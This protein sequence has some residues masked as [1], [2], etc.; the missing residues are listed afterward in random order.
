MFRNYQFTYRKNGKH[1]FVPSESCLRRGHEIIQACSSAIDFPSSFFHYQ[2]GGHVAALH[3]H[4]DN[5]YFFRID[6]KDFFYSISR[7]RVAAALHNVGFQK[8]RTY[9][10][11]SS[12]KNPVPGPAYSLPIGFV[13]S[14]VLATLVMLQS[15][16]AEMLQ[17]AMSKGVF[18][19]LYFDD[20]IGSSLDRTALESVF[21]A[22]L[23]ACAK[24]NFVSNVE[25]LVE[26]AERLIAFNCNL[27]HGV[28]EVTEARVARFF[29]VARSPVAELAF[30]QYRERIASKNH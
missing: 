21:D 5:R 9:A 15:P 26:P 12:V 25:K 29:E 27:T 4:L 23:E 24:A 6:L 7:N 3:R 14:P 28:A 2:P 30:E 11:W 10:K 19:S 18:I 22:T 1:I 13:Q 8:A 17:M 16:L 20:F